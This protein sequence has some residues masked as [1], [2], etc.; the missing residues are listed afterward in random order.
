MAKRPVVLRGARVVDPVAGV[1]TVQDLRLAEGQIVAAGESL[2]EPGDHF[3]D[4]AGLVA[5]P[6][7]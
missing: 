4:L 6:D 5:A 7:M 2:G 3:V 1:D